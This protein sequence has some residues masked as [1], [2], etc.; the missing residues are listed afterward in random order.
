MTRHCL[1]FSVNER[2]SKCLSCA[3][4]SSFLNMLA[5]VVVVMAALYYHDCLLESVLNWTFSQAAPVPI[6]SFGFNFE[7]FTVN[8]MWCFYLSV[9][10]L[11]RYCPWCGCWPLKAVI[12]LQN[13]NQLMKI[14]NC[15]GLEGVASVLRNYSAQHNTVLFVF[16][17]RHHVWRDIMDAVWLK[18]LLWPHLRPVLCMESTISTLFCR[19]KSMWSP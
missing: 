7:P 17:W 15:M 9:Y 3:R 16:S 8:Q 12:I 2:Q 18:H 13:A 4:T 5:G 1:S 6:N 10:P 19:D 11:C 14:L